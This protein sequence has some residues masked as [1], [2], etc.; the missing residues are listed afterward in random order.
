MSMIEQLISDLKRDEGFVPHAY[1]DSL[2]FLTIGYGFL[3]DRK[4]G[5]GVP[6]DIA[7]IWLLKLLADTLEELASAW[8]PYRSQPEPVKRA[9]GNMAYQLGVPGL[10]RFRRM[11]SALE[12]GDREAA[13]AEAL[14]SLWA[15]QTPSRASRV[16]ALIRGAE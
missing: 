6:Q 13:A 15:R 10:M 7:H 3:V 5:G 8:P 11:L 16:A 14:D 12:R 4:R 1:Q 2:G 9:L